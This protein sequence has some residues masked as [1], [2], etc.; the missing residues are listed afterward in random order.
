[1]KLALLI[2]NRGFFPSSVISSA[3]EEMVAALKRAGAEAIYPN[4]SATRHGVVRQGRSRKPCQSWKQAQTRSRKKSPKSG[5]LRITS[6]ELRSKPAQS[7]VR[8]AELE[9]RSEESLVT[10]LGKQTQRMK[11]RTMH[12]AAEEQ[13]CMAA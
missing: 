11:K 5:K 10:S 9:V 7:E 13:G 3:R 12:P 6:C 2:A 1:M 4:L 8:S